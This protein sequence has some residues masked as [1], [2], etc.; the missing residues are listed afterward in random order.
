M[1]IYGC[2]RRIVSTANR[3]LPPICNT[4]LYR[5]DVVPVVMPVQ[6]SCFFRTQQHM[7]TGQ[8]MDI[9]PRLNEFKVLESV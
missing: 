2:K 6:L 5:W 7:K 8:D 9:S 3:V 4:M 1:A